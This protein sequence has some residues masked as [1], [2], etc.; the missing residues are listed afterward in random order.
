M[1]PWLSCLRY[2][3]HIPSSKNPLHLELLPRW[4][5]SFWH[6]LTGLGDEGLLL[7]GLCC[8][9]AKVTKRFF[10]K[11][12]QSLVF[13]DRR[14]PGEAQDRESMNQGGQPC[15]I[16]WNY[17]YLCLDESRELGALITMRGD[18]PKNT[19]TQMDRWGQQQR[20]MRP[21]PVPGALDG[22]G[23]SSGRRELV[24]APL[25]A[26]GAV[27]LTRG[28]GGKPTLQ[29]SPEGLAG[30]S[31]GCARGR[32][33]AQL[34]G[35]SLGE[36]LSL[37]PPSP[38]VGF[39]RPGC[40]PVT[41]TVFCQQKKSQGL[42]CRVRPCPVQPH[43]CVR[44]YL[45]QAQQSGEAGSLLQSSQYWPPPE[46]DLAEA[47]TSQQRLPSTPSLCGLGLVPWVAPNPVSTC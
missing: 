33:G 43:P 26:A 21:R 32:A 12:R 1:G 30:G 24:P 37:S 15:C 46:H 47:S 9:V 29:V 3:C 22:S 19:D 17:L 25:G 2:M 6:P 18:S 39:L 28:P 41:H 44:A 16:T 8:P 42:A 7:G 31:H 23:G 13:L 34:S 20:Q 14:L 5:G 11:G 27:C 38:K 4:E 35:L 45:S 36:F 10:M 40:V